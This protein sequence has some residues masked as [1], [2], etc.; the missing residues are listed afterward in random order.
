MKRLALLAALLCSAAPAAAQV[1]SSANFNRALVAPPAAAWPDAK[2]GCGL[3]VSAQAQLDT[4]PLKPYRNGKAVRVE[5]LVGGEPLT[6]LLDTGATIS[7]IPQALADRLVATGRARITGTARVL[8]ASG[9]I[10]T[11][12]V[13]EIDSLILGQHAVRQVRATVAAGDALLSFP[14]VDGIGPFTID[15]RASQ[16]IFHN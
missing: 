6:M 3:T 5:V 8:L 2:P 13:V 12:P 10:H 9:M 15:T 14:V 11:T 16:L 1:P 7:Q 4:V